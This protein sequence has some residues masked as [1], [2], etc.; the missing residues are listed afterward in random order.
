MNI[1]PTFSGS[2]EIKSTD[3][4]VVKEINKFPIYGQQISTYDTESGALTTAN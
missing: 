4:D 2:I 3:L 1:S